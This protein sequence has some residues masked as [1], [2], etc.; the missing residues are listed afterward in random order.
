MSRYHWVRMWS[1]GLLLLGLVGGCS[2]PKGSVCGECKK[3]ERCDV[4]R[5]RCVPICLVCTTS[6]ECENREVCL[7][8]CCVIRGSETS[9]E[10]VVTDNEVSR[11]E[12]AIRPE[13]GGSEVLQEALCSDPPCAKPCQ[14]DGDCAGGP[15]P[16]CDLFEQTCVACRKDEDCIA[17]ATCSQGSCVG[18]DLC[19]GVSC[20]LGER[21]N[22]ADGKCVSE[23]S[24]CPQTPC[25]SGQC[26]LSDASCGPC[27]T[28]AICD[29]CTQ[30]TDCGGTR[31][32]ALGAEMRCVPLCPQDQCPPDF[33][34]I[35][36]G[37]A[38]KRC[39]PD[40]SC[41]KPDICF[42]FTCPAGSFCCKGTPGCQACCADTDCQG[43]KLCVTISGH[44][45]CKDPSEACSP[46]CSPNQICDPASRTCQNDCRIS[47]SCPNPDQICSTVSGMCIP[48]D[49]RTNISCATGEICEQGTGKCIPANDC[50][51]AGN[52]CASGSC[53]DTAT[54]KCISDCTRCGC[55][56]GQTC[57]A[58]T[59]LCDAPACKAKSSCLVNSE[60]CKGTC[61]LSLSTL[62]FRCTCSSNS[63]CASGR[64]AT[65]LLNK[66]C[67]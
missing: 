60:C 13:D 57:N 52:T 31:C 19:S 47:N 2:E 9:Q 39:I 38:G 12:E 46:P 4:L 41:S 1:L 66:Y 40:G 7:D 67:N 5:K 35:N 63:D 44:K 11:P 16:Y 15:R 6:I 33:Q 3:G 20:P 65:A 26:C 51:I 56:S 54:G 34:C 24:K 42:G 53:C 43:G 62:E 55:P 58:T 22:P 45:A 21:C 61:E 49:C 48:K 8:G 23:S 37:V 36:L 59:K 64:C 50:R 28:N 27:P 25:P 32:Q 17:P 10:A 30:D 29:L 18:G 14:S